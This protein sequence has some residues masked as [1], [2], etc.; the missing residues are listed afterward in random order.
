LEEK[1]ANVTKRIRAFENENEVIA[2]KKDSKNGHKSKQNRSKQ[3]H[4]S[5]KK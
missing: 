1:I 2:E 3:G 4:K 5:D